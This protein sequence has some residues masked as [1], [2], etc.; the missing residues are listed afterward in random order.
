MYRE[1]SPG[2]C[3]RGGRYL[4]GTKQPRPTDYKKKRYFYHSNS[5]NSLALIM[6]NKC[7]MCKKSVYF[8]EQVLCE[9]GAVFHEQCF[10][11]VTCKKTLAPGKE[12]VKDGSL[13][14]E[15]HRPGQSDGF[16]G[17]TAGGGMGGAKYAEQ[18]G[19]RKSY[20]A[21][22]PQSPPKDLVEK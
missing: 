15:A 21:A 6:A 7:G 2:P 20:I 17:G 11:C 16:R 3:D 9:G 12:H 5:L 22:G 4:D 18:A 8:N 13:Y 14:C 19:G 1:G 10:K